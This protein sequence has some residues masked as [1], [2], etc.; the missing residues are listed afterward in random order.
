MRTVRHQ[1][2]LA[3]GAGPRFCPGRNLAFLEAKTRARDD[4]PQLPDRARQHR[5]PG[6]RVSSTG[7][8]MTIPKGLRVG[9]SPNAAAKRQAQS[10]A[11]SVN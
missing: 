10:P 11:R 7:S 2:R 1:S 3:F 5:R 6:E 9:A 4:R 8:L